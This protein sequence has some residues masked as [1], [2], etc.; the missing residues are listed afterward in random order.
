[1]PIYEYECSCGLQQE[2]MRKWSDMKSV[3]CTCGKKMK[4]IVSSGSFKFNCSMPTAGKY[5]K[6]NVIVN[7]KD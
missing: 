4:R 5:G 2:E 7:A 3:I 6:N 1:M